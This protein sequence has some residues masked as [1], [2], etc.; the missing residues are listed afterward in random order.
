MGETSRLLLT[1]EEA[2]RQLSLSRTVVYE[3]LL[4]REIESIKIGRSRR[5]PHEALT[6][7]IERMR[8]ELDD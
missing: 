6:T 4:A 5:I 8:R 3:L 2:A 7:F 1:P